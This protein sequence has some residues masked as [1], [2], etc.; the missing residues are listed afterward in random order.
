MEREMTT[1]E[2]NEGKE[3]RLGKGSKE[4][5]KRGKRIKERRKGKERECKMRRKGSVCSSGMWHR[6]VYDVSRKRGGLIFKCRHVE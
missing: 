4:G 2:R 6:V 1:K 3:H 5:R